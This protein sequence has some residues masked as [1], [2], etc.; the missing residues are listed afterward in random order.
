MSWPNRPTH[1]YIFNAEND[2][3]SSSLQ[4]L[5]AIGER[6]PTLTL[7]DPAHSI[8]YDGD[9]DSR[10]HKRCSN[11][12]GNVHFHLLIRGGRQLLQQQ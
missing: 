8:R 9:R 4:P 2:E 5:L 6:K 10:E 12:V 7:C 3:Y 1:C 11:R